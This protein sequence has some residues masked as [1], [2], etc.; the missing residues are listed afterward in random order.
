MP[1]LRLLPGEPLWALLTTPEAKETLTNLLPSERR[2]LAA[3]D[4]KR[5]PLRTWRPLLRPQAAVAAIGAFIALSLWLGLVPGAAAF[6]GLAGGGL[7]VLA[8]KDLARGP[9]PSLEDLAREV[10][11]ALA[12]TS[13][14]RER[15]YTAGD[16]VAAS[17]DNGVEVPR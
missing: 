17:V 8:A 16:L 3:M 10:A 1:T 5:H 14:A 13:H 12:G 6:F 2:A 7:M 11:E 4:A 9:G 15:G